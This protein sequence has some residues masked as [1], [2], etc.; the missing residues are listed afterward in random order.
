MLLLLLR[1]LLLLLL[2]LLTQL[3]HPLPPNSGTKK[4]SAAPPPCSPLCP[5]ASRVSLSQSQPAHSHSMSLS[6][7]AQ[8]CN[9]SANRPLQTQLDT[10]YASCGVTVSLGLRLLMRVVVTLARADCGVLRERCRGRDDVFAVVE[11]R[12]GGSATGVGAVRL[13]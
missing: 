1:C 7:W 6:Y 2:L 13:V 12:G 3:S 8:A 10:A 4:S 11:D 9:T 5:P